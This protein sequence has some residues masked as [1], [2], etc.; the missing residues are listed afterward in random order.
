MRIL[1]RPGQHP[2][3]HPSDHLWHFLRHRRSLLA[4][5]AG[6]A[7]QKD[8]RI[9]GGGREVG[10]DAQEKSQCTGVSV[11]IIRITLSFRQITRWITRTLLKRSMCSLYLA[12]MG[13]R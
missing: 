4:H 6:D 1:T 8:A 2:R 11:E 5:A 12:E 10:Q 13:K 7:Q 3:G 9:C